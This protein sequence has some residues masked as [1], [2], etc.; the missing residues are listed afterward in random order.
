LPSNT[1]AD[2]LI[3]LLGDATGFTAAMK[4]AQWSSATLGQKMKAVG[5]VMSNVGRTMTYGVTL[6][7]VAGL[8][9]A[10]KAAIDEEK[11]MALLSKA[12]QTNA[13]ATDE[14]VAATERWITTTQNATGVADGQLRPALAG[15]VAVTKDTAKAQDLLSVALDI[16]AAKGKP[17]E[18]VA[19]ALQKAYLGN[20]GGLSRLGIATKDAEGKTLSFQQVMKNA[21]A[22][23]GGAAATA[24]DTTAGKMAILKARFADFAESIGTILIPF[25]TR[26]VE[27]L[28][29]L[30]AKFEGLSPGMQKFAVGLAAV[31]A[32]AGPFLFITGKLM[33]VGGMLATVLGPLIPLLGALG[34]AFSVGGLS[35]GVAAIAAA[36]GPVGLVAVA[37]AAVVAALVLA[38]KYS[39]TFRNAVTGLWAKI[40][41]GAKWV[42]ATIGP[43]LAEVWNA[44]K[45]AVQAAQEVAQAFFEN[46]AKGVA[47][48]V[49]WVRDNWSTIGPILKAAWD[50]SLA[51][52]KAFFEVLAP[53]LKAVAAM[54]RGDFS[55]AWKHAKEAVLAAA[56]GMTNILRGLASLFG[57]LAK[58]AMLALLNAVKSGITSTVS[59]VASLPGKAK[60]AL[61]AMP[62]LLAAVG[63]A[64]MTGLWNAMKSVWGNLIGWAR[65]LPGKI[66]SVFSGAGSWLYAAGRAILTGLW[67]GIQSMASTVLSRVRD[68]ASQIASAVKGALGVHSPSTV[69]HGIGVNMM[70]GMADGVVAGRSAVDAALSGV[71]TASAHGSGS[72]SGMAFGGGIT[73]TIGTVYAR[74]P[75]EAQQSAG[76]IANAV[77]AKLAT[78][79]RQTARGTA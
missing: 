68:I 19:L 10:V 59:F 61:A 17:V 62:G 30:L 58:A 56:N 69:F 7:I 32:A 40:V 4:K 44:M 31:A 15:L 67:N 72:A 16:S 27:R 33:T 2:V 20:V 76:A 42:A 21:I 48:V 64:A 36:L 60:A 39:E 23:Y 24:A 53:I 43:A 5:G 41:E 34:S 52:T 73:I 49:G 22:T 51:A 14:Q 46:I 8:G 9:L 71:G 45:P 26:L 78:A 75:A 35:A 77:I 66:K 11:E 55:D 70:Q 74:N 6:P 38:W 28:S 18:T 25:V 57:L 54:L 37:I 65:D 3:R 50:T 1:S 47:L 29:S 12:L 79:K 13:H 63:R